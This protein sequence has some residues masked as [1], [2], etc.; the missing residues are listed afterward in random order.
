MSEQKLTIG[1]D[2]YIAKRWADYAFDLR[3]SASQ[4]Q[5]SYIQLQKWLSQEIKG[6]EV[7]EKTSSQ[8]RRIWLAE[9]QYNLLRKQAVEI[10]SGQDPSSRM[11]LHYGLALNVFPFFR[12]L[13]VSVG[14][15]IRLQGKCQGKEVRQRLLEKYQSKATVG[16]A[17]RRGLFN[18]D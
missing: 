12:D 5:N 13:C 1:I 4:E 3:S 9:D 18:S 16:F 8:L 15:L 10:G 17:A 11:I 2:R 6:K 14:R 7:V